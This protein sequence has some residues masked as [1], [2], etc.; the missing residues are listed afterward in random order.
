MIMLCPFKNPYPEYLDSHKGKAPTNE[1]RRHYDLG[2][3]I[4]FKDCVCIFKV[5]RENLGG[6]I[7]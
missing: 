7:L 1:D 5:R 4:C 3:H 2:I 6:K